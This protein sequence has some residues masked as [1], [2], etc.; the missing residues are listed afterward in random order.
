M[1]RLAR[2]LRRP[3]AL[4]L[5]IGLVLPGGVVPAGAQRASRSDLNRAERVREAPSATPAATSA[6]NASPQSANAHEIPWLFRGSDIPP[7]RDWTFGELP[8]GLR[9]ALR[10][11]GVPPGQVAIRVRV[12]AG[13]LMESDSE[14]GF[15][16]LIEHLTF[17]GSVYV[18]DGEAKRIW[19][20]L[21]T[22]FG[23]DTNAQTTPT[24]TT[25]KLDLPS[26][27]QDGLDE[28]LKILSGMI[29]QP[30]LTGSALTAE[31][32]VVLAEQREQP[33]AQ[34]RF[35]DTVRQTFFAGQPLADRSPIGTITALEGATAQSVQA[36]HKRWYRPSRVVVI[37]SG[38][39]DPV[40]FE[41]LVT[42]YFTAWQGNGPPPPE[43][44]FGKPDPTKP[45]AVSTTE[46][47]LPPLVTWAVLRPWVYRDDTIIFNQK[48]MVDQMALRLIN[49]RLETRAR[50]GGS[51]IQASVS[52][53]DVSRSANGTFVSVLPIGDDW[54]AA[55]RDVRAAIAD[56]QQTPPA[57]AEIDREVTEFDAAMKAQVDTAR[58]EQGAQQADNMGEAIDIRETIASAQVS[59]DIFLGARTKGFFTP[60]AL[61]ESTRRVFV[62]DATHAVVNSRAADLTAS[63]RLET[64]LKADVSG[65][66]NAR[67]AVRKISFAQLPRLKTPGKIVKRTP[68]REISG[69]T[70]IERID[71]ANG[72]RLM[73]YPN[74]GE[75]NRVYVRVRFGGGLNALPT[76]R[77]TA[78][79]AAPLTLIAGGI[80]KLGQEELDQ[81]TV[82]RRIGMSFDVDDDAF[83][84]SAVTSPEDMA[85]QLQLIAAKLAFPRWDPNPLARAKAVTLAAYDSNAVSPGG[86][87]SRDLE[88][89]L[90]AGDPRWATATPDQVRATTPASFR[91]LWAP[92]LASGPVEV[93]VFGDFKADDAVA[94]VAKSLGAI[95]PRRAST[96]PI[97]PV[98]FPASTGK[99]VM[100]SHDGPANQAVAVVAWPTGGGIDGISDSR[101]L[102]LLAQIFSDRLFDRLRSEAGA[103][104][105]P[106]VQSEW[107]VGLPSGGRLMAIGQVPPDK[108]D[109]FFTLAK[110]IAADLAAKPI[111]RDELKRTLLPYAQY[112]ARAST[113]NTFWLTQL[114]GASYDPRRIAAV[115][116]LAVD[117]G[118]VTPEIL[119]QVAQRY[120]KPD[121]AFLLAVTP[122]A[123]D[124]VAGK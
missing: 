89:L 123:A 81:L 36:F 68:I 110:E 111:E 1:L 3:V 25:Y 69:P 35:G 50:S 6:T 90:H 54:E 88:G 72:V 102:E 66:A 85:D 60:E 7:D 124:T 26:A 76:D 45:F 118:K 77:T 47:S 5:L 41:Q 12:D 103:S 33:G 44:D 100:L 10:R 64:A 40:I 91:A 48:R 57:Q 113:G 106:S 121:G 71:F 38:D 51:F 99:P 117:I 61:L 109:F 70:E 42:K 56:A 21:G 108:V 107:P 32:P 93:Q 43:P 62:G 122:K 84:L 75:S 82:G 14:R 28:S 115:N 49:R 94:A 73:I 52:L 104:Y 15:A 4:F 20:R 37:I 30:N 97:P 39:V 79:W 19:Q 96:R 120:L 67:N 74:S 58:A 92:I 22:T 27:T 2:A 87:L 23:S 31:R 98:K 119:Q 16:H 55:L 95:A 116:S 9:Y 59:Y 63:A 18:P 86:I 8:N 105:S 112:I 46:P 13:S 34:V 17:R 53:N 101:R 24:S 78:A 114:A 29:A 80:G 11:N 83:V 65:L